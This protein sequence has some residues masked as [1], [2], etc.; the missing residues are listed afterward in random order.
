[1]TDTTLAMRAYKQRQRQRDKHAGWREIVVR[2]P[3]FRVDDVRAFVNFIRW[4]SAPGPDERP[5]ARVLPGDH[6]SPRGR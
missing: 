5:P 4:F 3:E 1:M 6:G 2:V